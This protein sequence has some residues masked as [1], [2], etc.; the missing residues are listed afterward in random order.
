LI[1]HRLSNPE[2]AHSLWC[3]FPAFY[4]GHFISHDRRV[5]R[6]ADYWLQ[7]MIMT[8][9]VLLMNFPEISSGFFE[10][11]IVPVLIFPLA[12]GEGFEDFHPRDLPEPSSPVASSHFG[13]MG[14][15]FKAIAA[16]FLVNFSLDAHMLHGTAGW[17]ASLGHSLSTYSSSVVAVMLT[18]SSALLIRLLHMMASAG[19]ES[20]STP[21]L[22][23]KPFSVAA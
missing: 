4:L 21:T 22:E 6:H 20:P 19:H 10:M 23:A 5:F 18:S 8:A 11:I 3:L 2:W 17:F 12:R 15:L 1:G 14:P 9:M 13:Y 16:L 7:L